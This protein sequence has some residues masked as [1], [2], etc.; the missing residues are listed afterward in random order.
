[1]SMIALGILK[2]LTFNILLTLL[3]RLIFYEVTECRYTWEPGWYKY[4]II[5]F[6]Q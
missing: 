4:E 1:M 6:I 5:A 3:C 2:S